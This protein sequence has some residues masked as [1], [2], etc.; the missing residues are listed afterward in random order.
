MIHTT[1]RRLWQAVRGN[2][3]HWFNRVKWMHYSREKSDA[4]FILSL[5]EWPMRPTLI[6]LWRT[7]ERGEWESIKKIS[8]NL[9][10]VPNQIQHTS[11]LTR[12][13]PTS[14]EK[15]ID[16]QNRVRNWKHSKKHKTVQTSVTSKTTIFFPLQTFYRTTYARAKE[17]TMRAQ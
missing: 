10:F 5:N 16:R 14:Y 11:V 15:A 6:S 8:E 3:S 2:L 12:S 1:R 7:G 17:T 9:T 13:R 4:N